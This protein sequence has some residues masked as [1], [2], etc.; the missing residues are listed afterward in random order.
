V[1]EPG[2]E[3]IAVDRD[4]ALARSLDGHQSIFAI[5]CLTCV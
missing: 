3:A 4:H 5:T 2:G 1:L